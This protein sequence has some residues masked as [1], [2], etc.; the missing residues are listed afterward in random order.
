ML[1]DDMGVGKSLQMLS[2]IAAHP[3]PRGAVWVP[4]LASPPEPS[5]TQRDRV[6][7][8]YCG[9]K[10]D[11][12]DP[13]P[14]ETVRCT[15]C[16]VVHHVFCAGFQ[17]HIEAFY[18]CLSCMAE[19]QQLQQ[20]RIPLGC[21]LIV[22]PQHLPHQWLE[23]CSKHF[24]PS[25][26]R[27][28]VYRGAVEGAQAIRPAELAQYDIVLT[29]YRVLTAEVHHAPNARRPKRYEK[30]ISPLRL[31]RFWRTIFDEAQGIKGVNTH[32]GAMISALE[33]EHRCINPLPQQHHHIIL[34][35]FGAIERDAY[36]ALGHK[37]KEHQPAL[38]AK[39]LA[40]THVGDA[41][42]LQDLFVTELGSEARKM[43]LKPFTDLRCQE[44]QRSMLLAI[45]ALAGLDLIQNKTEPAL[46]LYREVITR[47]F[48]PNLPFKPDR[49]QA[50]HA[51][52]N[53]LDVAHRSDAPPVEAAELADYAEKRTSLRT[54]LTS[55]ARLAVEA[56]HGEWLH[57]VSE[58]R[59]KEL[60][61]LCLWFIP[62]L[63]L[64]AEREA[65]GPRILADVWRA[66][67]ARSQ[68]GGN[69]FI[70]QS[71]LGTL[72]HTIA[73][74]MDKLWKARDGA[75][76][77]LQRA[78]RTP[79]P[80]EVIHAATCS[81]CRSTNHPTVPMRPS[82]EPCLLCQCDRARIDLAPEGF[83]WTDSPTHYVFDVEGDRQT[84]SMQ[85]E[86]SK[87]ELENNAWRQLTY[88]TGTVAREL[89]QE[90]PLCYETR[91]INFLLN[92]AHHVCAACFASLSRGAQR[93]AKL[94]AAVRLIKGLVK[95]E[96]SAKVLVFSQWHE[97]LQL[98]CKFAEHNGV[99]TL[100]MKS[101]QQGANEV[102]HFQHDAQIKVLCLRLS[103]HG[104]A[105]GLTLTAANHIILLDAELNPA[106]RAQALAR[107]QR[108]GQA[109]ETH[110]HQLL[111]EDSI[112]M[113]IFTAA[114]E[115][116]GRGSEVMEGQKTN[117]LEAWRV[118]DV[119]RLMAPPAEWQDQNTIQ[120]VSPDKEQTGTPATSITTDTA[121]NTTTSSGRQTSGE[122][123]SAALASVLALE[124]EREAQ[125]R[126]WAS[127]VL[128]HGH[129][130]SRDQAMRNLQVALS[131]AERQAAPGPAVGAPV[132]LQGRSLAAAVATELA[133]LPLAETAD[134]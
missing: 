80:E 106:M 121:A 103:L 31:V 34:L 56:A 33:T 112:E 98:F 96:P 91:P 72:K 12:A 85:L 30:I 88:L 6:Q 60:R 18:V 3:A 114:E 127:L 69:C 49:F 16:R 65:H 40:H 57:A 110:V 102:Q 81:N 104:G 75:L 76:Q 67:E 50:L 46:R 95:H 28:F 115:L 120:T 79:T 132:S 71:S 105:N 92:C 21:T 128:Y 53:F 9:G 93:R 17:S 89:V 54:K 107:V 58:A 117:E 36:N 77:L 90:C 119:L 27:T 11:P 122:P 7:R 124:S 14:D 62:L 47:S 100:L 29:T 22:V 94:E 123:P 63:T 59:V 133:K 111:I 82:T 26:F 87:H 68:S 42:Q 25:T 8:C 45:N 38:L 113:G 37:L 24:A 48:A 78:L 1:I 55:E 10:G 84:Y 43:I 108:V 131:A 61:P 118:R 83:E 125:E 20:S 97:V 41:E 70:D 39:L 116:H 4:T 74:H 13:H 19:Q 66:L 126:Y 64:A 2:L 86:A 32:I 15:G 51:V 134:K 129:V 101:G 109:R 5:S 99:Q 130:L 23:E 35:K 52:H 73:Q 44:L